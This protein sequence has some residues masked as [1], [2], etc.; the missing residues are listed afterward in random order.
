MSESCFCVELFEIDWYYFTGEVFFL[1]DVSELLARDFFASPTFAP[2]CDGS[3]GREQCRAPIT[4]VFLRLVN[5]S[6]SK[7]LNVAKWA[8]GDDQIRI[9]QQTRIQ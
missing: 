7:W 9:T 8:E 4:I 2:A 1:I 5:F 6:S 3:V